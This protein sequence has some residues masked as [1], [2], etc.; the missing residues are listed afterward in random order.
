MCRDEGG[1]AAREDLQPTPCYSRAPVN[2]QHLPPA[3][4]AQ[5]P[6]DD[7]FGWKTL[8]HWGGFVLR[9]PLRHKLLAA[10]AFLIVFVLA[11]AALIAVPFRYQVQATLLAGYQQASALTNHAE[12]GLDTPTRAARD[13]LL[14][15]E[16]LREIVAETK[17]VEQMMEK[18]PWAV[19]TKDSLFDLVRG[20]PRTPKQ[21]E[22]GLLDTLQERI[23][24]EVRPEGT[25]TITFQWWDAELARQIVAAAQQSFI[26]ARRSSEVEAVGEAIAILDGQRNRLEEEINGAIAAFEKKQEQ[27]RI[28]PPARARPAP[29][30]RAHD[31]EL[32]RLQ[33]ELARKQSSLAELEGF[34]R[35]RL[36]QLQG[37]LAQQQTIYAADHPAVASTRRLL[38]SF[39]EPSTKAQELQGEIQEIEREVARRG[40]K[41][42]ARPSTGTDFL[43]ARLRLDDE[44]PRLDFERGQLENLLR[45]HGDIRNRVAALEVER[46]TAE[47]AFRHRYSVVTPPQIPRGPIKPYP[48][49]FI[50]GG[51]LGGLAFALF[52]AAAADLR[53][54]RVIERWQVEE[55]I[56]LPVLAEIRK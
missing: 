53:S 9:A 52:A 47:A 56:G 44:D 36:A 18:R 22:D 28:Q 39:S 3:P 51:L 27:L 49:I 43:E 31:P 15:R 32:A 41:A 46:Q 10:V 40:G 2:S 38:A 30:E 19:R 20:E 37:E 35:Q 50:V 21:I 48:M 33:G 16:N 54:G 34:R 17:F 7:L 4:D 25:I 24:V 5:P 8:F 23:W 1:E 42:V 55:Q 12:R 14:R 26:E 13:V 29:R 45:Q 11:I 6:E